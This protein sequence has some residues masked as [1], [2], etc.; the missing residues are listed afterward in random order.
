MDIQIVLKHD[1]IEKITIKELGYVVNIQ[2]NSE[3]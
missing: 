1:L 2:W 3:Q